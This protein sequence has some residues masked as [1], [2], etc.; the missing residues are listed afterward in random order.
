MTRLRK[1]WG[2]VAWSEVAE[3]AGVALIAVA[4]GTVHVGLA[5]GAVGL[6]LVVG[7][8]VGRR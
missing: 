1:A 6:Y 2:L 7:A 4:L 5:L 8:N 3:W